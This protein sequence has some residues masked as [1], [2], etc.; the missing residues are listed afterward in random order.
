MERDRP[1]VCRVPTEEEICRKWDY[2]ISHN[3]ES[4]ENWVV[5]KK[6]TLEN[7]REGRCILYYGF[8]GDEIICEATAMTCPEKVQN[9]QGLV[10]GSTVYL[11]AFRTNEGYRGKG[12]FS[13]LFRYMTADLKKKGFSKAT[14]GVE[15]EEQRN[16][17]IYRHYGFTDFLKQSRETYPDGTVIDVEYYAMDL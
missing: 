2:E 9:S 3:E 1:F 7:V 16:K 5:W 17:Q 12:Y 13:K 8:L 15:S 6:E 4:R 11:A 14:V 10:D